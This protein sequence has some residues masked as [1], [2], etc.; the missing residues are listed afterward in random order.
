MT[1]AAPPVT[2]LAAAGSLLDALG[3]HVP[4]R[5]APGMDWS[6][7]LVHCAQSIEF[8]MQGFPRPKPWWFR[9]TVGPL[10]FAVFSRR[11]AMRHDL[12]A[13][14]PGAP[15]VAIAGGPDEA[16]RRLRAAMAAF[17]AWQGPLRPHFAYGALGK[18]AYERAHAMHLA[19][20][21]AAFTRA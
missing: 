3:A 10:A 16:A 5:V 1:P 4:V 7:T 20:H 12:G 18:A 15:P 19:E 21:L 13:P 11:G 2:T 17:L 8:S 14:I 9:H 6:D